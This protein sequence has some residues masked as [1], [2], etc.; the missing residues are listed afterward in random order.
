MNVIAIDWVRRNLP[1][2][3][4]TVCWV[5]PDNAASV[6]NVLAA[7]YRDSGEARTTRFLLPTPHDK[8]MRKYVHA[9]GR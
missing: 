6:K 7:G 1:G 4:R 9:V 5:A 3:G 2:V 8:E